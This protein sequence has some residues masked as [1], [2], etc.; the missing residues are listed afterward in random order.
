M[1][2]L[3]L[4]M[5]RRLTEEL[6][7]ASEDSAVRVAVVTGIDGVF[8]SGNDLAD[9]QTVKTDG[10]DAPVFHFLEALP[11]FSKPL[12][13]SVNGLAVGI[14]TTMLLHC[15]LVYASSNARFSLPFARLG[16]TPEAGSS[17]LLPQ[18]VGLQRATEWL[19][20]GESFDAQCARDA[21]LVNEIVPPDNLS[22]YVAERAA[23]LAALP[24]AAVR[25]TKSLIRQAV[26]GNLREV[27]KREG[28]IFRERLASPE[29]TEAF[30]A[31]FEKRPPDFSQ[32]E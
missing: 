11:R 3:T 12:I 8:T 16:L 19:M 25:Q 26:P 14:G 15:D 10:E 32:F 23:T 29:A 30:T 9:F 13:A 22:T 20:L 7:L 6:R 31:F 4:A 21:G 28:A 24:P 2:A 5:Y 1:N 18:I 17:L 27:M